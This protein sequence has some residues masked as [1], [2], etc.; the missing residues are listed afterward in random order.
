[1]RSACGSGTPAVS[2]GETADVD[3]EE[4]ESIASLLRVS[5]DR[6]GVDPQ[7]EPDRAVAIVADLAARPGQSSVP[8]LTALRSTLNIAA[9]R[10]GAITARRRA[11]CLA[12]ATAAGVEP[13]TAAS[14]LDVVIATAPIPHA[15]ATPETVLAPPPGTAPAPIATPDVGPRRTP[16]FVGIGIVAAIAV[17]GLVIALQGG[18][19]SD[20]DATT[21]TTPATAPTASPAEPTPTA[22]SSE[23]APDSQPVEDTPG[24]TPIPTDVQPENSIVDE[25]I[26]TTETTVASPETTVVVAD[27]APTRDGGFV[28]TRE[29]RISDGEIT[30]TILLENPGNEPIAGLHREFPP[31]APDADPATVVWLPTPT[32]LIATTAVFGQVVLDPGQTFEI[33][34]RSPTSAS[35]PTAQDVLGWYEAW[36]LQ[37]EG[38]NA[39]LGTSAE[40]APPEI[41]SE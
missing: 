18:G 24:T 41:R 4:V 35:N 31:P 22:V 32:S 25:S 28:V 37:A 19:E 9:A 40:F 2:A 8:A 36:R 39:V 27:F 10:S 38:L 14:I 12:E 23:A 30:T 5:V 3:I 34:Y 26:V 7:R 16:L 21:V 1:M 29:W 15:L 33:T 20:P 6:F 17:V 11:E 13:D